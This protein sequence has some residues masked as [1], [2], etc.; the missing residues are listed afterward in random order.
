[1]L[2]D[3]F[4][5]QMSRKEVQIELSRAQHAHYAHAVFLS[6]FVSVANKGRP[7]Q[8]PKL[9]VAS[10]ILVA[11]SNPSELISVALS[12]WAEQHGVTLEFINE[13]NQCRTV[14]LNDAVAAI[15]KWC[16]TCSC[17]KA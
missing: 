4:V 10:S 15:V 12:D 6:I 2:Q 8:I 9:K 3:G 1:M 7:Y 17:F 5:P 14:S 11:R 13:A 16:W